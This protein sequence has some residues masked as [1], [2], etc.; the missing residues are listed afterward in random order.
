VR[1]VRLA[2]AGALAV[3]RN[4]GGAEGLPGI[5][6]EG[7]RGEG[8][9]GEER[10]AVGRR[11]ARLHRVRQWVWS[12]R[13]CA[14]GERDEAGRQPRNR[15]QAG[16]GNREKR[17]DGSPRGTAG[18]AAVRS[19]PEPVGPWR[20]EPAGGV[21]THNWSARERRQSTAPDRVVGTAVRQRRILTSLG[22]S[23]ENGGVERGIVF[24][25]GGH[26]PFRDALPTQSM[27]EPSPGGTPGSTGAA[28]TRVPGPRGCRSHHWAQP[29]LAQDGRG[30][31]DRGGIGR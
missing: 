26:L 23:R 12:C 3:S 27:S 30:A 2:S 28:G 8:C 11:Q 4:E 6:H 15:A 9:G 31:V 20:R 13:G 17:A 19:L 25:S 10:E 14:C 18:N 21:G 24:A 29:A 7:Q 1:Q 16:P 5:T 22:R